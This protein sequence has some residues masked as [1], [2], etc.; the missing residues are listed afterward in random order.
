MMI[1]GINSENQDI[2]ETRDLH[3]KED[4]YKDEIE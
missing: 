3:S 4:K 2:L 1:L